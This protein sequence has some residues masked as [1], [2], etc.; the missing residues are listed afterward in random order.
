MIIGIGVVAMLAQLGWMALN[1]S[2]LPM[3][4]QFGMHKGQYL[5]VI[6]GSFMLTEAILRPY[7]GALSDKYGRKPFMLA[8]P[9]ISMFTAV[10]T[11]YAG[12]PLLM[13]LLRALDGVGLAAFWP[14]SFAAMSDAVD[15]KYRSTAM[16]ILNGT[17]MAGMALGLLFGGMANDLTKSWLKPLTGAFYFVSIIFFLTLVA[18]LLLFPKE[19]K[20][21]HHAHVGETP[22]I[23]VKDE[24]QGAMR[25]VPDMLVLSIVVFA[26]MGLLMPI[27]KLYA[28]EQLG[29]SETQFGALVAPLAAILGLF[30]VPFGHLA[31]KWGKMVSVSYGM[32]LCAISMWLIAIF[33]SMA[34]MVVASGMLGFGFVLAFPSWMAVISLA[35]PKERRGQ[36]VG[37]VGLTQGVGAMIGVLVAPFIYASDWMSLPRLGVV[38][39]NLPFYLCAVLLSVGTVMTFTWIARLRGEQSGGRQ[40]SR[41]ERKVVVGAA[42][43]GCAAIVGWVVFRYTRPCPED[44]VAWLWVHQL[45][46]CRV[47][48]AERCTLPSFESAGPKGLDASAAASKVYNK[49]VNKDKATYTLTTSSVSKDGR[50]AEV[51]VVFRFLKGDHAKE[52]ITLLK[53]SSGEWKISD[54]HSAN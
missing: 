50:R 43:L 3:W 42:V 4:V 48:K 8:G 17:Q 2:A 36:I 37:A 28:T 53:Q 46:H 38:H 5:G 24:V 54:R 26:A 34:V 52:K 31:D 9:L 18:G 10:A 35:A 14:S 40:I 39:Y 32:M 22:H 16:G 13:I 51:L 49:W 47:E 6:T 21:Q 20:G 27:V 19:K 29:M 33:K 12:T 25:I 23:P 30:A 1:F 7:L 11:I 41:I 45:V 44:R 15:E